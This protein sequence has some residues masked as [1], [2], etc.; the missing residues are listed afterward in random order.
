MPALLPSTRS[1]D[2]SPGSPS[3]KKRLLVGT[4][5]KMV[6]LPIC[7]QCAAQKEKPKGKMTALREALGIHPQPC[8]CCA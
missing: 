1:P 2:K 3:P 4:S 5:N 7:Q 6:A 8:T